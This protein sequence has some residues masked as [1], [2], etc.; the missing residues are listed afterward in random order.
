MFFSEDGRWIGFKQGKGLWNV[1]REGGAAT[2]LR[3]LA[4]SEGAVWLSDGDVIYRWN[5]RLM[6]AADTGDAGL[7]VGNGDFLWP[8]LLPGGRRIVVGWYQ[9]GIETADE[10]TIWVVDLETGQQ[11][12]LPFRGS[13]PR[14]ARSGHLLF[15]RDG[16]LYAVAFDPRRAEAIGA[17]VKV[18]DGVATEQTLFAPPY[19]VSDTGTLVYLPADAPATSYHLVRIDDGGTIVELNAGTRRYFDVRTSPDGR[20]LALAGG[21]LHSTVRL[22]DLGRDALSGLL[23]SNNDYAPVWHPDNHRVFH[24]SELADGRKQLR[25][26]PIG[27]PSGALTLFEYPTSVPVSLWTTDPGGESLLYSPFMRE[28]SGYDIWALDARLPARRSTSPRSRASPGPGCDGRTR[29][30]RRWSRRRGRSQR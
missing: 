17:P 29:C 7:P 27:D 30:S 19:A 15:A 16:A 10:A 20:H 3:E 8:D 25:E 22:Y 9:W 11:R 6:R 12:Q 28:T 2:V 26:Q 14:Y 18:L 13:A 21:P 5:R 4:Q 24:L 23:P 1:P